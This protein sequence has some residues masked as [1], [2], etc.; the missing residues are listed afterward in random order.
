MINDIFG[1]EPTEEDI[2]EMMDNHLRELDAKLMY[3]LKYATLYD[4]FRREEVSGSVF[5]KRYNLRL[6]KKAYQ[7]PKN[8][9][10][11]DDYQEAKAIYSGGP[12]KEKKP[13][14]KN[15]GKQ[16]VPVSYTFLDNDKI[17]KAN[18]NKLMF[19]LVLKRYVWKHPSKADTLGIYNKYYKGKGLLVA[20]KPQ[21]DFM[22]MFGIKKRETIK[23]WTDN[24]RTEG[25]I[26]LTKIKVGQGKQHVYILGHVDAN[27]NEIYYYDE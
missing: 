25:A 26:K 24:L 10:H 8:H 13:A 12:A 3:E 23:R 1:W 7:D 19:Y 9:L 27:G 11:G 15:N 17:L 4:P 14:K 18:A 20:T 16:Y 6:A 22:K 2:E 5:I 21:S